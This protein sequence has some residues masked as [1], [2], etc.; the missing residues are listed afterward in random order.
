[1]LPIVCYLMRDLTMHVDYLSTI[2]VYFLRCSETDLISDALAAA[3]RFIDAALAFQGS[4]GA[5]WELGTDT[6]YHAVS[7]SLLVDLMVVTS[8]CDSLLSNLTLGSEWL[9]HR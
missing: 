2:Q 6:N 8:R 3:H 5:F 7:L 9:A 4:D 1:M